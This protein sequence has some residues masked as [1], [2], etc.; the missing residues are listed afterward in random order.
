M[1]QPSK[2]KLEGADRAALLAKLPGWSEVEGR[3]AI[4]KMFTFRNFSEAFGFMTRV[5]L[6]AEKQN[7]HP[8]WTNVWNRVEILLT[9]HDAGG[10]TSRDERL[11]LEIE[12]LAGGNR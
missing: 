6:A 11:A 5:A 4:R 1:S 7:H 9:S 3:D 8:E 2:A 12:A 10:L